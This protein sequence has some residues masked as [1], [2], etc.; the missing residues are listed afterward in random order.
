MKS[1]DSGLI[2]V[3]QRW[4]GVLG[5]HP[6]LKLGTQEMG[7][8]L[9]GGMLGRDRWWVGLREICLISGLGWMGSGLLFRL[10]DSE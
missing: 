7:L 1:D 10:G 8:K 5:L 3:G 6:D 4:L 9:G 2:D